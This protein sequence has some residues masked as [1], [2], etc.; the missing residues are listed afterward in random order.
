MNEVYRHLAPWLLTIT[1]AIMVLA[2]VFV[3][4]RRHAPGK[5]G[6]L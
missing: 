5:F 6:L 2:A 1:E 4:L 3:S